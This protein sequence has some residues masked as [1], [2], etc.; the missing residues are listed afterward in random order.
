DGHIFNLGH[1]VLPE[2]EVA[3][4]QRVVDLVHTETERPPQ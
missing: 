3:Q 4:L 2:T 1:G